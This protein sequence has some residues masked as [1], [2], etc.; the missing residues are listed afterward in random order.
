MSL[1]GVDSSLDSV[2]LGPCPLHRLLRSGNFGSDLLAVYDGERAGSR[3]K[4]D[5]LDGLKLF[6]D[7]G[8]ELIRFPA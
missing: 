4:V 3:F 7:L 8:F 2:E 1:I 6:A 5:L